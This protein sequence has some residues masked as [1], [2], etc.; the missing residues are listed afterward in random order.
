MGLIN[1]LSITDSALTA[2]RL[3]M[4][5][6]ANNTANQNTTRTAAGGPYREEQVVLTPGNV[7]NNLK[8]GLANAGVQVAAIVQD[9]GKPRMVYDP[10]NA[11]ADK[12]GYVAY[13]NI[14]PVEEMV[15]MITASRAYEAGVTS[16][17]TAVSMAERALSIGK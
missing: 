6:I 9:A 4:D 5:V 11:D 16:M 3:Q 2:E 7:E 1:S 14:N 15:D 12:Q 13:P 8:G 10:T 17:S